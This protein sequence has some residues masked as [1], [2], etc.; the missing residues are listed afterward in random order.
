MKLRFVVTGALMGLETEKA[1]VNPTSDEQSWKI[2]NRVRSHHRASH[3]KEYLVIGSENRD[4]PRI[5]NVASV[6]DLIITPNFTVTF[7]TMHLSLSM[8]KY[9]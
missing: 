1:N 7:P 9:D 8:F 4:N 2:G 5:S 6:A 3:P